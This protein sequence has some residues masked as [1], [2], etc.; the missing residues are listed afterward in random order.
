MNYFEWNDLIARRFFNNEM[1]GRE[2]LVYVNKEMIEQLGMAAGADVEDFIQCIKVG[3][4][5]IENGGLCQKALKLFSNWRDYELE[6]PPYI[7]YLGFFVLAATIEGDFNQKAYY[8]RFWDLLGEIDKSGTPQQFGKTEMLWEDLEKWSTEDKHEEWGRFTARIRGGMKHIGRPL[9]QTLFSDSERKYL[10]LIFDEAELDPTDN[11]SDEV[12]TR[13]L[14]KRG[15]NRFAK[16]T[17]RLLD[18]IQTENAEMKN[19]LIEF[20]LDEL[21]EWDGSLPDL[22]LDN[23]YSSQPR[24]QNS[25]VGLRIC[26]E[27]DKFSGMVT[28]TLRLKVNRPFPDD[29]LNFE[30]QGEVYSCVETAP[31]NWSTKLKGVHPSQPFDATTIDWSNGAKFEDKENKFI[32]RLKAN[33]VRLFLR[34]ERERLPDW[35]ESQQLE[36]GCEFLVA[37]HSSIANK[38]REWG[39]ISCEELHE[40]SSSDLPHEW[41]LFDGKGAHDSCESIDVLTLSNLLKLRLYGGIKIGRSNSFLSYGPPTIILERGYGNEKVMLDG[42]ELIRSDTDVPHWD[43][44]GDAPVGVPLII[45]VVDENGTTLKRRRIELKKPELPA[46]FQDTP[47]RDMS[48][49][50]L[51]N[52]FSVPY[53]SGAIVAGIDPSD[54]GV[55]PHTLPTYLSKTIVFLGDKPG[56]IVEWPNEELPEDWHPVWAVAKYGKDSWNVHFCGQLG[57][58]EDNSKPDFAT[59]D[60]R[61]IKRWKEAVWYRR[62]RTN[63]PKIK[64]I[65]DMWIKCQEVA[66]RV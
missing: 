43:L 57:I 28:S 60:T 37:C 19:A 45:E 3:P 51:T 15:E 63:A 38:I 55:F 61:A 20:V 50:I 62:K 47:L 27:L 52:D 4:D 18:S 21:T 65:K 36:R 5:W 35:I 14:L 23:Q 1:A 7:A 54:W 31:P 40:I 32:A 46:D 30:Y 33:Q 39:N 22:L 24:L 42:C 10:P 59:P 9:S 34:G 58:P 64:T 2:V 16:R 29:G 66:K 44:P 13:I 41:L 17:L 8:P 48:G 11:P 26:L 53:A 49:K 6:Y 56:E 12:M 25:R